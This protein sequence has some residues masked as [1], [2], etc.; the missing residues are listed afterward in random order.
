M[1]IVLGVVVLVVVAV[2]AIV[3][4][5]RPRGDDLH[6]VQS[7]HSALGTLETFAD[8]MG[9]SPPEVVAQADRSGD[10]HV[11][12]R[13]Y[14]R[15]TAAAPDDPAAPDG[16]PVDP[17]DVDRGGRTSAPHSGMPPSIPPLPVRGNA[18]FPDPGAPLR[19]D[20]APPVD[21]RRQDA[22]LP[23]PG[24]RM[25]RAQRHA[26]DSMNHRPRRITTVMIVVAAL[27]LFGVLAY[28]GSR[29]TGSTNHGHAVA[30]ATTTGRSTTSQPS[31]KKHS[32]GGA[33]KHEHKASTT[34]TTLPKQ[35]V[36]LTSTPTS[37]TYPVGASAYKVTL[38]TSGPCWVQAITVATGSTLWEGTLQAGQ[39]QVIPA[40]GPVTVELGAPAA[41]LKIDNI[42]VV[43]P[44]PLHTPFV[45]RFQPST[46]T[47]T[48]SGTTATTLPSITSNGSAAT[49]TLP[50]ATGGSGA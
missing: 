11:R 28:V 16:S 31:T 43:L 13:F 41:T 34:T 38:A 35:I 46:T 42:P 44:V 40:S 5:R 29:R 30:T 7:Y 47:P 4:M 32:G 22:G 49:T 21:H 45:A 25:D 48:G 10:G 8:R 17:G 3:A 14:S 15:A 9:Q 12:P 33:T 36:A 39:V 37:A 26:L 18:D 19:F 1:W 2:V 50:P 24:L 20:D 6:S 23:G 27:V